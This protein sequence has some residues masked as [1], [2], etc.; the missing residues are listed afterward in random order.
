MLARHATQKAAG[1]D[2]LRSAGAKGGGFI[3]TNKQTNKQTTVVET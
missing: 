3:K 2:L 1:E